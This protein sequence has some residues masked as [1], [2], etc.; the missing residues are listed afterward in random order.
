MCIICIHKISAVRVLLYELE[1]KANPCVPQVFGGLMNAFASTWG[2]QV[3]ILAK[4]S[5][6]ILV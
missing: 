4:E 3:G 2:T 1:Y 5:D 6:S